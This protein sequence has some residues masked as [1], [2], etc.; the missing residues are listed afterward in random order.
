MDDQKDRHK[1]LYE[2]H[3]NRLVKVVGLFVPAGSPPQSFSFYSRRV[4]EAF[5]Y[6]LSP[7][8]SSNE[9]DYLHAEVYRR[10]MGAKT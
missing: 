7:S 1:A 8:V 5:P 3:I 10:A 9:T 4:A 2:A 6:P